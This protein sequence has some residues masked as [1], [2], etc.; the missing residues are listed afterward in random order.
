MAGAPPSSAPTWTIRNRI[1]PL[2]DPVVMGILNLTPDSFSDGGELGS[3]EEALER[4]QVMVEAGAGILDVGGESTRPGAREVPVE[5]E[6]DRILPFLE[7]AQGRISV[8][9]SVDT[10]KAA[11][12]RAA[13]GAGAEIV[14][15][16][17]GLTWDPEM[18][19]LVADSGAGVV[20]MHMR[21]DPGTMMDR[22][23][24]GDVVPEVV[25]ELRER[26]E[27]GRAAGIELDAM[28][29]DPGIGFAKTAGQSL[30]LLA[31]L[32]ELLALGHPLLVGPSRKS[33]LGAV[34]GK[35]ARERVPGTVAACV[36]AF[37]AGARVF[38]VHDVGPVA[39]ALRVASAV[40]D[41]TAGTNPAR[42]FSSPG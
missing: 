17:S 39:D 37:Q 25:E 18:A 28:V 32:D 24:Y 21:G 31:R 8:P 6:I 4:A 7:A 5:E 33:F 27:A 20:V 30:E 2:S 40:S 23:S 36:L 41:R 26:V 34:L 10:R 14:N 9:V 1:L 29:V 12:A 11:V 3:V 35:P 22:T 13:L 19:P 38:R 16:V 15:D 42:A